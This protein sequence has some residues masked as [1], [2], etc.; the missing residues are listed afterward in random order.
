MSLEAASPNGP[1]L[2]PGA[3]RPPLW[4]VLAV[5][6]L[7]FLAGLELIAFA[8]AGR[9]VVAW[10]PRL[11][12]SVTV[13]VV[14][15]GLESADAAA[16]RATEILA[17]SPGVVKIDVLDP[18]PGD[19]LAG[20]AMGL[21]PAVPGADPPRLL[22][23][24]FSGGGGGSAATL[25]RVLRRENLAAA[26]DDHGVWT[27]PLERTAA[28]LAAVAAA[29]LLVLL[30]IV[31]T[32]SAASAGA[33]FRR[34]E[35]RALLLVHLGATD[36]AIVGPFRSRAVGATAL[37]ALIGAGAAAALGAA[38]IWSPAVA[39]TIAGQIAARIGT[40]PALETWDLAA[41]AIWPP[42][43]VLVAFWAAGGAAKARLR[44]V[45]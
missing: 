27:G 31:W 23:A 45:A 42:L 22:A 44:A 35:D 36:Q 10:S 38:M 26:I 4:L 34:R 15:G 29:L 20:M 17:W 14:G 11:A 7:S 28:A 25:V 2:L 21:G 37:G 40:A 9:A 30:V 8:A 3:A 33:A 13:A 18:A 16:A 32:L 43:A 24:T 5:L 41:A 12:G 1:R 39:A 6:V 19:S